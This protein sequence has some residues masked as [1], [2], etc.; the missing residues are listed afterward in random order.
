[1]M[2]TISR[3]VTNQNGNSRVVSGTRLRWHEAALHAACALLYLSGGLVW[4]TNPLLEGW[5]TWVLAAG[6][7]FTSIGIAMAIG[8]GDS[9][10][11]GKAAAWL[12]AGVTLAALGQ[13]AMGAGA[14]AAVHAIA[15]NADANAWGPWLGLAAVAAVLY[16]NPKSTRNIGRDPMPPRTESSSANA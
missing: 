11:V 10:D 12:G 2:W 5:E 9:G 3:T 1:M 6:T 16:Y 15:G 13:G 14:A 8:M 7:G 4:T